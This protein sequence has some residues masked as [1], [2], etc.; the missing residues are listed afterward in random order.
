MLLFIPTAQ[1]A[2]A[3][4]NFVNATLLD[5]SATLA[6]G[7]NIGATR[8]AG[9]PVHANAGGGKSV[10]WIYDVPQTGYLTV[11]TLDSVTAGNF[12][13]DTVLAIYTGSAVS[14]LSEVAS[15]DD[16]SDS[17]SLGSKVI[18]PVQSGTRYYIAVD[19]WPYDEGQKWG[20]SCCDT[21]IR[22]NSRPSRN[23]SGVCRAWMGRR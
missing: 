17:D 6:M 20:T 4:D 23:Y 21:P 22:S 16:D 3:N 8:E 12:E 5:P 14:A 15:N 10:W 2:P 19:G 13:M 1:A 18:F 9:E 11:S 7:S